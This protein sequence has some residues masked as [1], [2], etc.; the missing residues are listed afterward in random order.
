MQVWMTQEQ[1]NLIESYLKP[2]HIMLEYGAGGSTLHFSKYVQKYISIEHDQQWIKNINKKI[3]SN[4]IEIHYCPPNRHMKLPVWVGNFADFENYIN[5][6]DKLSYKKYDVV[7]IDGRA[8]Q[9]CA[10]KIL[11]YIDK[12]SIVF[13]HDFV[14]RKRYHEVFKKYY[15]M[16]DKDRSSKIPSLAVFRKL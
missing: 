15:T 2:E 3:V 1:V 5:Y 7:L 8:R 6:I 11:P 12:N 10:K 16:I 4:N 13:C 14:E 9:Y